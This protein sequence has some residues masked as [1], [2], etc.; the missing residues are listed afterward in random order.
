MKEYKF[1]FFQRASLRPRLT[2]RAVAALAEAIHRAPTAMDSQQENPKPEH[3]WAQ[4]KKNRALIHSSPPR[5]R[6]RPSRGLTTRAARRRVAATVW[7]PCQERRA[8]TRRGDASA[9]RASVGRNVTGVKRVIGGCRNTPALCEATKWAVFVS[10]TN[11]NA[12]LKGVVTAQNAAHCI[13][14]GNS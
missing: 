8:A 13:R 10:N 7:A 3:R 2:Q 6:G 4:Q 9:K 5:T 14:K 1:I 11:M 12:R